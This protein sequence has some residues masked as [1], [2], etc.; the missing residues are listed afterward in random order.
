MRFRHILPPELFVAIF[1]LLS[2]PSASGGRPD[3]L[4][5]RTQS[6]CIPC[7]SSMAR[8]CTQ[9]TPLVESR[10][11]H[12]PQF[13]SCRYACS[14]RRRYPCIWT[15]LFLAIAGTIFDSVRSEKNYRRASPA[16]ATLK[17]VQNPSV[18]SAPLKDL[19]H[20]HPLS[21]IFR[22][23]LIV[24]DVMKKYT[25]PV[26]IPDTLFDGSTPRLSCLELRNYG[27]S[28]NSPLCKR[29]QISRD[30]HTL[31]KAETHSL[32]GRTLSPL[33]S[34]IETI[35]LK[36]RHCTRLR[37]F[38]LLLFPALGCRCKFHSFD[39]LQLPIFSSDMSSSPSLP[40][41]ASHLET[42]L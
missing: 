33:C 11:F 36:G 19:Y 34:L 25:G 21:N 37:S 17:L 40:V 35:A 14:R 31:C 38:L 6:P 18:A 13:G 8:G 42:V 7:L 10:R 5:S 20:L 16:F 9:S 39:S 26:F 23:L 22:S 1:S 12:H 32:V 28:W 3:H 15:Q 4:S 27:I 29:T 41:P 24:R 2:L 30:I